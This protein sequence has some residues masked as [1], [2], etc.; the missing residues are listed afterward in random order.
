MVNH[1]DRRM[2]FGSAL[3]G[4]TGYFVSPLRLSGA[5]KLSAEAP[6]PKGPAKNVI[7]ILMT[8][9]PSQVDTLDLKV[10]SWTPADFDPVTV[11]AVDFPQ[12]LLPNLTAQLGHIALVRSLQ[13]TALVHPLLQNWTQIARNPTS[14]TGSIAPNIGSVVALETESVRRSDQPLPGFVSL[15]TGG[16]V[17]KQGYFAGSFAPFDV[18]AD[19]DGLAGLSSPVGQAE[20]EARFQLLEML[21]YRNRLTERYGEVL[22]DLNDFYANARRMMYEPE[23]NNAFEFSDLDSE[24]YGN[25]TFGDSCIVAKN[26]L[27]ADLGTH[28]VQINSRGWDH[29]QDIYLEGAGL[30]ARGAEF[31]PAVA[32]LI[33]DLGSTPGTTTGKTLLDETLIVAKGEF[34]R[35]IGDLTTR[36]GRDH[37]FVHSA[38]FAGGGTVGGR[39]IG[40]TTAD[41]RY[42]EDTGWSASRAATAGDVAATIYSALGIDFATVRNDDPL[43]RGFD[44]VPSTPW[45]SYPI[46]ELFQ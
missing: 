39:V 4:V 43:G 3:A 22:G 27:A 21:D 26:I 20:F 25:T 1:L 44:Y 45:E 28:Y 18:V 38:M 33:S 14:A 16:Q 11:G 36:D 24:R 17:S 2:F 42:I 29:H 13:T 19:S 5:R 8:G 35:T 31:D 9:A 7:F 32:N 6:A 12:G 30:Y 41:G 46:L 37:Y 34:G 40:Q 15:N 10:G 23:V